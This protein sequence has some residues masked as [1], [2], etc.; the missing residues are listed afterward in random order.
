ML[1]EHVLALHSGS[2][3]RKGDG[4]IGNANVDIQSSQTDSDASL[5]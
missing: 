1:S 2:K 5:R 3:K 4:S